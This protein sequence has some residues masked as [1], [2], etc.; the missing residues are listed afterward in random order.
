MPAET[1]AA[2]MTLPLSTNR[3]RSRTVV[4]GA[5]CRKEAMALQCVVASRPSSSPAFASRNAPVQTDMTTSAFCE[6]S[7]IQLITAGSFNGTSVLPPGKITTSGGGQ[8]ANVYCGL[9]VTNP[10]LTISP[11][12][13]ATV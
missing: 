13:A 3:Q 12:D 4:R 9:M 7:L 2:V 1:P 10:W 6:A 5:S 11:T 8:L